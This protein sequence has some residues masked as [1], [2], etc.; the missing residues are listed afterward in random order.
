MKKMLIAA[1]AVGAT[2]A[3]II[4]YLNKGREAG[5]QIGNNNLIP[6]RNNKFSM[7]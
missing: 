6:E 1:S 7:G 4:L 3:G 5:K 2:I